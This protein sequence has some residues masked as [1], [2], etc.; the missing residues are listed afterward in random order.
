MYL[1]LIAHT[2]TTGAMIGKLVELQRA[3][4]DDLRVRSDLD[5]QLVKSSALKGWQI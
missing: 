5:Q 1:H 4:S 3:P 2:S